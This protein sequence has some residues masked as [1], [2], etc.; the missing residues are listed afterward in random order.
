MIPTQIY[1][2]PLTANG[3]YRLLVAGQYFKILS[4]TGAVRVESEFGALSGLIAG[5][6]LEDTP[7]SYLYI[8]D[9]SGATNQ[10]SIVVGDEKFVDTRVTGSVTFG[11]LNTSFVGAASNVT[12]ASAQVL[13]ANASRKYLL[14]QNNAASGDIY[15]RLDGGVVTTANGI[16]ISSGGGAYELSTVVP[17]GAI[18]AIGSVA[19]NPD[20]II[21]EG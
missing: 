4:A 3:S 15:I 17:S 20:V 13:A 6:G 12:N 8:T 19:L 21:V 10:V 14:I 1:A 5:Y 18:T 7:F 16:K 11:P 9:Q 2:V